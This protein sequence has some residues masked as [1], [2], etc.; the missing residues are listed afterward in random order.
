MN[1]PA[2]TRVPDATYQLSVGFGTEDFLNVLTISECG[3]RIG[4]VT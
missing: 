1:N 4:H 3:G 2:S